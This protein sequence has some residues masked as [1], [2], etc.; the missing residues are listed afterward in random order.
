VRDEAEHKAD[1]GV[2]ELGA[3]RCRDAE[4]VTVQVG[5]VGCGVISKHYAANAAAFDVFEV[6]ACADVLPPAAEE[7]AA[8][9]GLTALPVDDLLADP[10][11]DVV[12]NLTPSTA[13]AEVTRAALAAGK[14]VYT[15]KPLGL[16][17]RE[18]TALLR[19]AE[20]RG[21]RIGCAPDIF[22]GGAYQAAREL[23]D[24]GAIGAPLAVS[25]AMLLEGADAWHPS[26][27]QFFQDGA[28]P[29][30]D[31][32]PYYISAIVALLGPVRRVAGFASTHRAERRVMVGPRAGEAFPVGTPTHTAATMELDGAVTAN[33]VASFDATD[34]Y[35]CDFFVHG[36]QGDLSLPDPNAFEGPLRI[37]RG[38]GDWES[39]A[40]AS[41]G[42]AEARGIGLADMA[43]AIAGGGD[44]RASGEL[45]LHVVDVA[46]SILESADKG[47]AVSVGTSAARPAP[48]PVEAS[49]AR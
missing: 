43:E 10:A 21:L 38:R 4:G 23:I 5:I 42:A 28:G 2:V 30:L 46:R 26:P 39:V 1:S 8:A 27:E 48:L 45:G 41:R 37:R 32:G 34:R 15:E 12:L 40:Y 20:R 16:R 25:A 19:E 11:I 13:H 14:H 29:L 6:V 3:R 18:A 33:L 17:V 44:H 22:L 31:M 36:A 24:D 49:V 7:L 35:V 9:H 47:R